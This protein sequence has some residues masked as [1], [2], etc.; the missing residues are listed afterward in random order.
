LDLG[1]LQRELAERLGVAE[2][3]VTN[4]ELNHTQ[5]ELRFRPRII[6]ILGYD[7][8]P[9]GATL[10]DQLLVS[11]TGQSLSPEAAARMVGVGPGTLWKWESGRSVPARLSSENWD[12]PRRGPQPY[13]MGLY[14]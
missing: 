4:W 12:V 3:T 11:R 8:R 6:N 13:S 2:S 10:A 7:P 9:G 1:L 5:P 14:T